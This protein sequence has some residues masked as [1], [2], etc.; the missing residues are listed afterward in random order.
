MISW[1]VHALDC[2]AAA[3]PL[4]GTTPAQ[5][6]LIICDGEAFHFGDRFCCTVCDNFD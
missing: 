2:I 3:L 1:R 5:P 6:R 4:G